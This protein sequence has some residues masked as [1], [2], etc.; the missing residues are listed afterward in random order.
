MPK[1]EGLAR[2]PL[3]SILDTE[4]LRHESDSEWSAHRAT[5]ALAITPPPGAVRSFAFVQLSVLVQ[6]VL[7]RLATHSDCKPCITISLDHAITP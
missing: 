7:A 1:E 2:S 4:A 3:S 6:Y 5:K